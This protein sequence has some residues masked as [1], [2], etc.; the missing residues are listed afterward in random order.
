MQRH[1]GA[2]KYSQATQCQGPATIN[3]KNLDQT[4]LPKRAVKT[5]S[6]AIHLFRGILLNIGK[7]L[8]WSTSDS[9]TLFKWDYVLP[10][11]WFCQDQRWFLIDKSVVLFNPN[12]PE[13]PETLKV[14]GEGQM[15]RTSIVCFLGGPQA[16]WGPYGPP[17]LTDQRGAG[18]QEV[19]QFLSIRLSVR[20]SICLSIPPSLFGLVVSYTAN[21]PQTSDV[22]KLGQTWQYTVDSIQQ[23]VDSR[24]QTADSRRQPGERRGGGGGKG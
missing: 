18:L 24:Q 15:A 3:M 5:F 9:M 14:R 10:S 7:F 19:F 11:G 2:A 17:F 21:K 23:T 22:A 20:L 8:R 4:S 13:L 16:I 6:V 12:G 1:L